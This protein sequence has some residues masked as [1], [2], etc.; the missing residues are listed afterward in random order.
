MIN[1]ASAIGTNTVR[2]KDSAATINAKSKSPQIPLRAADGVSGAIR[3]RMP[4]MEPV[5]PVRRPNP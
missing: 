2:P 3:V 1:V 4:Q 5:N